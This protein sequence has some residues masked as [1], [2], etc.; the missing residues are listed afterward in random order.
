MLALEFRDAVAQGGADIRDR[1]ALK[2]EATG[3]SWPVTRD[4][5]CIVGEKLD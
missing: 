3:E 1:L 2:A 5:R 4:S